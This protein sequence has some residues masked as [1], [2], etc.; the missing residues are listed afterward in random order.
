MK[1]VKSVGLCL[2]VAAV[3]VFAVL[4]T[5]KKWDWVPGTPTPPEA[6]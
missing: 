6:P 4:F 3:V 1:I 2:V 5:D